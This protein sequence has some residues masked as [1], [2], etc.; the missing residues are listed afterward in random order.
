MY[1]LL[2][3]KFAPGAIKTVV[4]DHIHDAGGGPP[5]VDQPVHQA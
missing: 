3:R 1:T 2:A 4:I 5:V